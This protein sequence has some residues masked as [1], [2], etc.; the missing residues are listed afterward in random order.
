MEDGD[1]QSINHVKL[2]RE[3]NDSSLGISLPT[4]PTFR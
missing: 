2:H 3:H 4:A 1:P